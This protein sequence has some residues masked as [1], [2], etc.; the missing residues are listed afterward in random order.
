MY[1]VI[2]ELKKDISE[3]VL[4]KLTE[5]INSAFDNRLGT[6]ANSHISSPYRFVFVGG[7]EEFTCLQIGLLALGEEKTFMSNVAV[8]EWADDDEP[9]E[10]ENLIE[11]YSKP[12]R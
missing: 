3:D 8:W 6:I 7:E 10:A 1:K 2:I 4:K 11:I 9:E 5:T 12:V